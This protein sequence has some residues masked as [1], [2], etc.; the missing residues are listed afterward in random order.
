MPTDSTTTTTDDVVVEL[1]PGAGLRVTDDGTI[2]VHRFGADRHGP[3]G[4]RHLLS[5]FAYDGTWNRW[6]RHPSGD[7]V[8]YLLHGAVDLA[9][10]DGTSERVVHLEPGHAAVVP[11]GT[12]HRAIVHAPSQMLFLTP[13]ST[14]TEQ[15][16]TS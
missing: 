6:E 11:A 2:A 5:S 4:P 12:W 14:P 13:T 8:V 1:G 9:L 16:P 7:E 15:R 3:V 10:D